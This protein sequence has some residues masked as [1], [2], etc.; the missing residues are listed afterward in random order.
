MSLTLAYKLHVCVTGDIGCMCVTGELVVHVTGPQQVNVPVTVTQSPD[1]MFDV[2][3]TPPIPGQYKC[4]LNYGGQL[5]PP[6]PI[7]ISVQP[8]IDADKAAING[9]ESSECH[10]SILL[11]DNVT[12]TRIL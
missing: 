9:L 6:S 12:C 10:S 4:T 11:H 8:A 7:T 5:V 2:V 3:F 1:N